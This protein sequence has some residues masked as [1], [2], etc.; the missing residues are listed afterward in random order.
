[1]TWW[2][3]I[4][5][6][7]LAAAGIVEAVRRWLW[8]AQR[9]SA[10]VRDAGLRTLAIAV[11]AGAGAVLGGVMLG[12]AGGGLSTAI[13]AAV[14]SALRRWGQTAPLPGSL[15]AEVDPEDGYGHGEPGPGE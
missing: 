13:A 12:L 2:Q 7:G 4:L 6:S 9:P 8:L 5:V 15:G 3:V 14:K 10:K 11:G 1:M